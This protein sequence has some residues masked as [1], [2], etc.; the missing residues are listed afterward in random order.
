M[1][2]RTLR[3]EL[4]QKNYRQLVT[5]D[6]ANI[7]DPAGYQ[8]AGR[9]Y[10]RGLDVLFRDRTT[11]KMAEY[12]IS[13]GF[14]DT[15]RQYRADPV[16]VIPT[17]AARHN[18]SVVGKYYVARMHSQFG[19]TYSYGSPRRYLDP[20][21]P[22]YNQA[23]LPAYQDLSL[24]VSYLTHWFGQFTIVYVSAS[25]VLNRQN[26]YGYPV[27]SAADAGGQYRRAAVLPPA[28][29]M[30]FVGV[31]ISINKTTKVDLDKRPD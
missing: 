3:A 15:R 4:Y 11:F 1:H 7:F 22:G 13:Y 17:F 28:P 20:N 5:Y 29:R 14:L 19:F 30:L 8:N 23:T 27:A 31:F 16:A 9:G 10:A 6:R 21:R 2:D 12:W 26:S 25:N 18:L 24:N